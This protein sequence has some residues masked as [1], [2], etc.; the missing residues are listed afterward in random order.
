MIIW[1]PYLKGK[2]AAGWVLMRLSALVRAGKPGHMPQ[3]FFSSIESF[4]ES[5]QKMLPRFLK[6]LRSFNTGIVSNVSIQV[7][8]PPMGK[9]P[10][11]Q[12]AMVDNVLSMGYL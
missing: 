3:G 7:F 9:S 6:N 8:V 4:S 5:G 11:M 2:G 1:E 12:K 10:K